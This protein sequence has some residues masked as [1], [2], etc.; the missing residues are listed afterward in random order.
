MA[1]QWRSVGQ[2]GA[3]L[4]NPEAWKLE[5]YYLAQGI[6]NICMMYFPE[7]IILGGG[8]M[9]HDGLLEMVREEVKKNIN[10]YIAVPEIVLPELGDNAGVIGAIELGRRG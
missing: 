4:V 10:G 3:E 9:H 6:T 5:A 7:V 1:L 8:V 2:A